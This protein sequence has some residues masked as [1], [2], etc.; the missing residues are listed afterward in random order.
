M[1][2]DFILASCVCSLCNSFTA[3]GGQRRCFPH[4]SLT[5]SSSHLENV[6][7]STKPGCSH[8]VVEEVYYHHILCRPPY[9][10]R[11]PTTVKKMDLYLKVTCLATM[12]NA[13]FC[14]EKKLILLIFEKEKNIHC[15]VNLA[16][17]LLRIEH[18]QC[19]IRSISL[20]S[21]SYW[22]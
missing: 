9:D 6:E 8:V 2:T 1:D 16:K 15:A 7:K 4:P 10:L 12:T 3:L 21:S 18:F 14:A 13:M 22:K 5:S 11:V 17:R 20:H 19:T